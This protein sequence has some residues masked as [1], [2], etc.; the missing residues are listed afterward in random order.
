[1]RVDVAS[2]HGHGISFKDVAGLTEAKMEVMEFVDYLKTPQRFKVCIG[3]VIVDY[4]KT[5]QRFKECLDTVNICRLSQDAA[6]IQVLQLFKTQII[7]TPSSGKK[8]SYD[9]ICFA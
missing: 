4:L 7:E 3:A 2:K 6:A 5:P 1:M 8:P 9:D